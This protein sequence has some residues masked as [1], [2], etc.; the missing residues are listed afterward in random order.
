MLN[1]N[2]TWANPIELLD[3]SKE[4]LIYRIGNLGRVPKTAGVYVFARK[5]GNKVIPLYIGETLDLRQRL[6]QHFKDVP[7]MKGIENALLGK[8]LYLFAQVQKKRG[9]NINRVL[10]VLQRALIEHALSVG[11]DLL[12]IQL[13]KAKLH[14]IEFQGNRT[15]EKLFTRTMLVGGS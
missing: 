1:I 14:K 10:N 8:R 13:T 3:G 4:N 2:A 15:S 9:Q 12:N 6:E 11:H 5:H 7:I